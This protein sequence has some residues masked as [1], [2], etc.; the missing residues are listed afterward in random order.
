MQVELAEGGQEAVRVMDLVLVLAVRHHQRVLR[1]RLRRQHGGEQ[2]VA[3]GGEGDTLGADPHAHRAGERPQRPYGDPAGHGVRAQQGVR[4]VVG[5]RQQAPAV[6]R[7]QLRRA[8]AAP[9]GRRE[10]PAGLGG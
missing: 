3:L 6:G 10:R 7:V 8:P 9:P 2:A 1:D 4:V 5:T